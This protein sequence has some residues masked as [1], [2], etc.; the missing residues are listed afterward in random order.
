[1]LYEN[2]FVRSL[3]W[4]NVTYYFT[5]F[6]TGQYSPVNTLYYSVIYRFFSLEPFWFHLFSLILHI[7]N[8]V[9][10]FVFIKR[11]LSVQDIRLPQK[12]VE[13]NKVH[14]IAFAT[15]LLFA[16][17]PIQVE[18]VAWISAS[19]NLLYTFFSLLA[20]LQYISY[21]STRRW[22][23]YLLVLVLYL[24]AFGSKEQAVIL[25][26]S[27]LLVDW[28]TG[29]DMHKRGYWLSM[30]PF[31]ALAVGMGVISLRAQDAG[32]AARLAN[33][34]Y[35]LWQRLVLACYAFTEYIFK[36]ILPIRLNYM[37]PFPMKPGE[38]MPLAFWFYPI[39]VLCIG[40]LLVYAW[41]SGWRSLFFG[42]GF[43]AVNL[44]LALHV[45]PLARGVLVADRYF[46]LGSI[47]L[48]FI[49]SRYL[50]GQDKLLVS[51]IK[52]D[53]RLLT[54]MYVLYIGVFAWRYAEQWT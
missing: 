8:A 26:V 28:Y 37:Y 36:G 17:H 23:A 24:L 51:H 34:Y 38:A 29:R 54:G 47:G 14:L 13:D 4:G 18:S 53:T 10:V 12:L 43:L 42:L 2:P 35:P 6:Y 49:I 39:V 33:E 46:Y 30:V 16:V 27:M 11:L 45:V 20:L 32:F 41:R 19:K 50:L 3:Q 15:A 48:F 5:H 31:F 25:P 40:A 1:M 22:W 44:A 52:L 21:A 7:S 9:L